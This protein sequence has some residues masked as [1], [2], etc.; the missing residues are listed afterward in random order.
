MNLFENITKI[1]N[2][3]K[4]LLK[5][6]VIILWMGIATILVYIVWKN[7]DIL[8]IAIR[9]ADYSRITIA[10]G[11]Y[12]IALFFA[13]LV[14]VQIIKCFL[15]EIDW[16]T[17]TRIYLTTLVARR[18][19]G[20]IWYIWGRV[21]FYKEMGASWVNVTV[22]SGVEVVISLVTGVIL[23]AFF[24]P[25]GFQLSTSLKILLS[26]IGLLCLIILHPIILSKIM[27]FFNRP[28]TKRP[29]IIQIIKWFF[30][31]I[32][33]RI[34][35]G[36]MVIEI[37]QAFIPLSLQEKYIIIGAYAIATTVGMLALLLPSNFGLTE[38]TFAGLISGIISLPMATLVAV[39]IRV[40][41]TLAEFLFGMIFYLLFNPNIK[42]ISQQ[43]IH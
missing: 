29:T 4:N 14:W 21:T 20:T 2:N 24:I 18:I 32:T 3:S 16:W 13:N 42:N 34:F 15:P 6:V 25:F 40:F 41:T 37:I 26:I 17:H 9:T 19:P 39:I 36:F 22:A 11:W 31:H 23:G 30:T 5:L 38:I 43:Q 35:T 28:L 33:L 7:R 27:S 10:C 12:L 1:R 8:S